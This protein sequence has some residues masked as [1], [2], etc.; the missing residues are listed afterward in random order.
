MIKAIKDIVMAAM[1]MV[2]ASK[3]IKIMVKAVKVKVTRSWSMPKS[4]LCSLFSW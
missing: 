3:V 4:S 2:R 1:S